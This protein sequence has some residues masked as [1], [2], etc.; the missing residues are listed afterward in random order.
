MC[1]SVRGSGVCNRFSYVLYLH[2]QEEP[3]KLLFCFPIFIVKFRMCKL[4]F[5]YLNIKEI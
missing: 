1:F 2:S 4:Q 3:I 5:A